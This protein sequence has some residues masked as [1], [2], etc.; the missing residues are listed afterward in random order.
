[1]MMPEEL[2]DALCDAEDEQRIAML[3]VRKA[4][5]G[6]VPMDVQLRV[7][8]LGA[9]WGCLYDAKYE[10]ASSERVL[11]ENGEEIDPHDRAEDLNFIFDIDDD[12]WRAIL[13]NSHGAVRASVAYRDQAW[14]DKRCIG[15]TMADRDAVLAEIEHEIYD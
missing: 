13:D 15:E 9:L 5:E 2:Y 7:D 14:L 8:M 12:K 11:D 3:K 10:Q 1:M 4:G 6:V